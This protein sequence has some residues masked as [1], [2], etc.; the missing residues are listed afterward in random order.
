[1]KLIRR[2]DLNIEDIRTEEHWNRFRIFSIL[3]KEDF[4]TKLAIN[5]L[6]KDCLNSRETALAIFKHFQFSRD[7]KVLPNEI[8]DINHRTYIIENLP[9]FTYLKLTNS[10][11]DS[12]IKFQDLKYIDKDRVFFIRIPK[13]IAKSMELRKSYEKIQ[14]KAL[15]NY[16]DILKSKFKDSKKYAKYVLP[17]GLQCR[18][19]MSFNANKNIELTNDLLCSDLVAENQLGDMFEAVL[20]SDI[21]ISPNSQE[22]LAMKQIL[23]Y[24]KDLVPKQQKIDTESLHSFKFEY[25]TDIVEHI[26]S[27]FELL[28]NPLGS[29]GELEFDYNDQVN[30]GKLI[31]KGQLGNIAISKGASLSGYLSLI[32]ILELL[33]NKYQMYIPLLS[34][35]IDIDNELDRPTSKSFLLPKELDENL[36][37]KR[38]ISKKLT[39]IY[40]DIKNW[41]DESKSEMSE[42]MSK[43]FTR[44]LL[45]M[46]HLTRFNLY[47]DINDMF[48][49]R[50]VKTRYSQEWLKLFYQRDPLFKK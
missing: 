7:K 32:D 3:N 50:K 49:L 31:S 34:D 47:L 9:I 42:E 8:Y 33:D 21:E 41:R 11:S 28:I 24:L 1:M 18:A 45:P 37:I 44:Y 2:K 25:T 15:A 22:A 29:R 5:A 12:F 19:V 23:E 20:K 39:D 16:R 36:D 17:V 27:N 35:F 30:I 38:A 26:I 10:F 14:F 46:S 4:N 40:S 6:I 48:R 43:E 13:E